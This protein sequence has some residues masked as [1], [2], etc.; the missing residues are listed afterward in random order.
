MQNKFTRLID[1][2]FEEYSIAGTEKYI[3][4]AYF[5][6]GDEDGGC[7]EYDYTSYRD[8]FDRFSD[9]DEGHNDD[10]LYIG[11]LVSSEDV[12]GYNCPGPFRKLWDELSDMIWNSFSRQLNENRF[13][14]T[15]CYWY[16]YLFIGK[17]YKIYS[18]VESNFEDI[19]DDD[20][21]LDLSELSEEDADNAEDK[22]TLE[23]I[24]DACNEIQAQ[25]KKL[26]NPDFKD[27]AYAL[28]HELPTEKI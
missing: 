27:K 16:N 28:I 23:F 24:K 4:L 25:F 15:N 6:E 2:I 5:H 14:G 12:G 17:D 20:P 10:T 13:E 9:Q 7:D 8:V 21:I 3:P 1:K 26:K 22:E 11:T 18:C 19:K